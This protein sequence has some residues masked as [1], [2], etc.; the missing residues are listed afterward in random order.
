MDAAQAATRRE[1]SS[2]RSRQNGFIPGTTTIQ[3]YRRTDRPN[4]SS[5]G[6]NDKGSKSWAGEDVEVGTGL[7]CR[8]TTSGET[9]IAG[10]MEHRI[11][12]WGT[13]G[14]IRDS[15]VARPQPTEPVRQ[16]M[17]TTRHLT[18][19]ACPICGQWMPGNKQGPPRQTCSGRCRVALCR[20]RRKP[21][22]A[23]SATP[24][25]PAD[26]P[27]PETAPR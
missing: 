25:A 26:V 9:K 1:S 2:T 27:E 3:N 10:E 14:P 7:R 23:Q 15:K 5:R 22:T 13:S 24:N 21:M 4:G 18:P 17:T 16:A 8:P 11:H 20:R 19:G 6:P 12:A